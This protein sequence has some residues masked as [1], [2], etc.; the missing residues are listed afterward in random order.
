MARFCIG[1]EES[2]LIMLVVPL[3]ET[4]KLKVCQIKTIKKFL[5][6]Q[7]KTILFMLQKKNITMLVVALC[8]TLKLKVCVPTSC[9]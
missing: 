6:L 4:L 8:Q 5:M 9:V 7:M 1:R 3:G 2:A